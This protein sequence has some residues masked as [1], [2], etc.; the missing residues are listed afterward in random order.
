MSISPALA[1][2]PR[3]SC[4]RR[5]IGSSDD[6]SSLHSITFVFGLMAEIEFA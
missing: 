1:A 6:V 5:F 4:V 3:R 2:P